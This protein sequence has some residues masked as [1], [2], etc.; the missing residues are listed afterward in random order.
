MAKEDRCG[1]KMQ[2]YVVVLLCCTVCQRLKFM[3]VTKTGGTS[4]ERAGMAQRVVGKFHTFMKRHMDSSGATRKNPRL[5]RKYDWF[6]VVRNPFLRSSPSFSVHGVAEADPTGEHIEL[7]RV[8]R[9]AGDIP[10]S[11]FRGTL[12]TAGK[13]SVRLR[14]RSRHAPARLALS[15]CATT[16]LACAGCQACQQSTCRR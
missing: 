11:P 1:Q 14:L 4:I 15:L 8:R 13:V 16:L 2:S 7:Q 9:A 6:T 3:H 5:I 12:D 10:A